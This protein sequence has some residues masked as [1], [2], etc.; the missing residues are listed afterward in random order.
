MRKKPHLLG[1]LFLLTC[2]LGVS[3]SVYG[4]EDSTSYVV[5]TQINV[6]TRVMVPPPCFE[7][8]KDFN[9]YICISNGSAIMMQMIENISYLQATKGMT[10]EFFRTNGFTFI[11]VIDLR[12]D[13]GL[14]GK[15]YKL[16]Y[17]HKDQEYVRYMVFGGDLTRTLWLNIT[18]PK[19]VEELMELEVLKSLQT[20]TLNPA[21]NEK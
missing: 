20:L 2:L 17:V 8:S 4:Q 21:D 9:G 7:S 18:Y 13:H 12:S 15:V 19:V 5:P 16:S 3:S 6:D 1:I 10:D 11:S 14:K